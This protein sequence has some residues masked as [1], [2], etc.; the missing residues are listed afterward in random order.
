MEEQYQEAPRGTAE[1]QG[2]LGAGREGAT[3]QTVIPGRSESP[4]N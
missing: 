3:G 4:Q 2:L 1:T